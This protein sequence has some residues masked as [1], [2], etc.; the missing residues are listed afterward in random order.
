MDQVKIVMEGSKLEMALRTENGQLIEA[1]IVDGLSA[2][3]NRL[4]SEDLSPDDILK[5]V[6]QCRGIVA[7]I[8]GVGDKIRHALGILA[9]KTAKQGL[10]GTEG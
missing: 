6:Y 9:R 8:G 10:H 4:L 3:I 1:A 2:N 7:A 5:T